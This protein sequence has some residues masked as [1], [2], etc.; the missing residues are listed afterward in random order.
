MFR[1]NLRLVSIF[2]GDIMSDKEAIARLSDKGLIEAYERCKKM[3]KNIMDQYENHREEI[4]KRISDSDD[5][6]IVGNYNTYIINEV[7]GLRV[8][9][10]K[11]IEDELSK[12]W[13]DENRHLITKETT[14]YRLKPVKNL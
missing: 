5:N 4:M 3:K 8:K 11:D 13:L 12:E 2:R 10:L 1:N 6:K 9:G 14:S 7:N